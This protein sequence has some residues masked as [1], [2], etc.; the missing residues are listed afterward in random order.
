MISPFTDNGPLLLDGAVSTLL[1]AQQPETLCLTNPGRV[2]A[3]HRAYVDA[4][5]YIIT[6]NSFG[7]TDTAVCTAAAQLAAEVAATAGRR[8]LVAGSV[9]P[10]S[11]L[12]GQQALALI[13]G[14]V[15]LLLLETLLGV[16]AMT[17]ALDACRRAMDSAGREV[18]VMVSCAINRTG[19]AL[20]QGH[21]LELFAET[22][23]QWPQVVSAGINCCFCNEAADTAL[24]ILRSVDALPV[25]CHPSAGL[26]GQTLGAAPFA[27][28]VYRMSKTYGLA[29]VGGCCGTTPQHI[30]ALAGR[31]ADVTAYDDPGR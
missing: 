27:H 30:A 16:D 22:A 14:G 17:A 28:A 8:V 12:T 23:A 5:A 2:T 4:G 26:P 3:L 6:T 7:S 13:R 21:S 20:L 11:A 29:A 1:G 19:T 24:S 31:L 15:D 25:T 10:Y 18:P 9:G